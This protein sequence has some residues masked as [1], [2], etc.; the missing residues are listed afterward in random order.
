MSMLSTIDCAKTKWEEQSSRGG[1]PERNNLCRL[2]Q[3]LW[4]SMCTV[5]GKGKAPV[6]AEGQT[7][8]R[9]Y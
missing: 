6:L 7:K 2:K 3:E 5:I 8:Q 1:T 9:E 4:E